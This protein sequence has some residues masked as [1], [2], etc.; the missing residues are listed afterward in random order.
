MNNLI[1]FVQTDAGREVAGFPALP[2]GG[3]DCVTRAAT[4]LLAH[5][6][7]LQVDGFAVGDDQTDAVAIGDIYTGVWTSLNDAQTVWIDAK[8]SDGKLTNGRRGRWHR[9]VDSGVYTPVWHEVYETFFGF[10]RQRLTRIR[11]TLTEAFQQFGPCVIKMARH[12]FAVLPKDCE[13]GGAV[14]DGWD[15]RHYL[16]EHC[17]EHFPQIRG[18]QDEQALACYMGSKHTPCRY[19]FGKLERKALAVWTT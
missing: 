9:N 13:A 15:V 19:E 11:P 16:W 6:R 18:S 5:D 7:G 17:A 8:V 3:G 1:G 10:K 4:L 2:R 14:F 12:A